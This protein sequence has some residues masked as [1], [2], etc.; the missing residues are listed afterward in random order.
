MCHL[1]LVRLYHI[2]HQLQKKQY[3]S[4][5]E[6]KNTHCMIL[7]SMP[8]FTYCV[9]ILLPWTVLVCVLLVMW[10]STDLC[11]ITSLLP[12]GKTLLAEFMLCS[13]LLNLARKHSVLGNELNNNASLMFSDIEKTSRIIKETTSLGIITKTQSSIVCISTNIR[14]ENNVTLE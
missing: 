5:T 8:L 7:L 2:L 14:S 9:F 3:Q 12:C 11:S 10:E 13:S 1:P 4:A 6:L